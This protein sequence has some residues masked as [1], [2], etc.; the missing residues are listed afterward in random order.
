MTDVR[1]KCQAVA[2]KDP[3]NRYNP[4]CYKLCII[5]KD[6]LAPDHPSVEQ[7][8]TRGHK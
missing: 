6:I 8:K 7:G 4:H 3:L 1:S 5:V 2:E